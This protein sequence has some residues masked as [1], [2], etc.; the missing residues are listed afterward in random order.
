MHYVYLLK[1]KNFSNRTYVGYTR[2][3]KKRLSQHNAGDSLHTARYM[4]W[5][6]HAYFAFKH[7]H[8]AI[9][10]EKYLKSHSGRA[11]ASKHFWDF[12]HENK[13]CCF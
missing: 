11:F 7:E 10:F 8:L 9:R 4:P 1:S 5:K 13:E 6:L 12:S 3:L 2:D